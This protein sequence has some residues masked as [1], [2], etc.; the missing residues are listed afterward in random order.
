MI[1]DN[2]VILYVQKLIRA[3]D[4]WAVLPHIL[5]LR[6]A[7]GQKW[8]QSAFSSHGSILKSEMAAL[9]FHENYCTGCHYV[10]QLSLHTNFRWKKNYRTFIHIRSWGHFWPQDSNWCFFLIKQSKVAQKPA[11]LLPYF[12]LYLLISAALPPCYIYLSVLPSR[13]CNDSRPISHNWRQT[14]SIS[15]SVPICTIQAVKIQHQVRDVLRCW[16]KYNASI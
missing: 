9:I 16:A 14:R 11:I 6:R 3:T 8:P 15:R 1:I 13:F 10:F 2:D 7:W 5:T 4:T 12:V